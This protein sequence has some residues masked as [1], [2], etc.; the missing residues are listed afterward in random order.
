MANAATKVKISLLRRLGNYFGNIL[1]DYKTVGLETVQ[2]IKDSSVKASV[3]LTG[4]VAA[5][6]LI[7]SN[8][9]ASDLN[10]TLIESAHELSLV[11]SA[12]RNKDSDSFVD[13]LRSAQRDGR[14]HHTNLGLVSL[15]WLSDHRDELDL[16]AAQ[17]K[18]THL[19]WYE[20]HKR[21]VD[22]GVL[23]KFVTLSRKMQNYDVSTDEWKE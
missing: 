7:K 13:S 5:G 8:P 10:N 15:V 11:G 9:T 21:V 14:L 17:C 1:N 22:I 12:I 6:I 20:F 16:Y 19:P 3:Y 4:F 23:G 18:Y 2:D